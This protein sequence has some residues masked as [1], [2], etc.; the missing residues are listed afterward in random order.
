[1]ELSNLIYRR[2][3]IIG[4]PEA[5]CPFNH[6][7]YTLTDNYCLYYHLDLIFTQYTKNELSMIL[8]GDIYDYQTPE[9]SNFEILKDLSNVNFDIVLS[10]SAKYA[11]RFVIIHCNTVT[12]DINLFH[13]ASASR[14][15]Y[16]YKDSENNSWVSSNP[17]I[18][19]EIKKIK[20]TEN[21]ELISF[22][23]SP[24]FQKLNHSSIGD[25]TNYDDIKQLKPNHYLNFFHLTVKRYF[26]NSPIQAVELNEGVKKCSL[27][28]K[29]FIKA[30]SLRYQL[31]IPLTAG[32]DS[33]C[34][35]AAS[36]DIKTNILYYLNIDH[37]KRNHFDVKT[38]RKLA[39]KFNLNFKP[40]TYRNNI[41]NSEFEKIYYHN[42]DSA[43]RNFYP[44]I[45]NYYS[46]YS[47]FLNL[48]GTFAETVKDYYD[49][50]NN[51]TVKDLINAN[52]LNNFN[53]ITNPIYNAWLKDALP[54]CELSNFELN[55]LFYWEERMGNWGTQIQQFKDVAQEEFMP[56]NSQNLILSMAAVDIKYRT[57][58]NFVFQRE[59]IR[60]LW[61]ELLSIGINSSLKN[62]VKKISMQTGIYTLYKHIKNRY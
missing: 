26:P 42:F 14:K 17:K 5:N 58:P 12:N 23:S 9:K 13:D 33:R 30:A 20:T 24:E 8:L 53:F 54:A 16:Y 32:I 28:L 3:Y 56:F 45:L 44:S 55:N 43:S 37:L 35:L 57:E 38:S 1:M 21:T 36:K 2:Q 51:A 50:N 62:L 52:N 40:I 48:P 31:M 47:K 27:M 59:M 60:L 25:I 22:Y 18:I 46:N 39:R 34:I 6:E 49:I 4:P 7:T 19:A 11:G 61:P 29:G 41:K 15:I 10:E